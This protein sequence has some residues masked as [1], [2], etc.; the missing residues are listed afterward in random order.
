MGNAKSTAGKRWP[1]GPQ[2]AMVDPIPQHTKLAPHMEANWAI[3]DFLNYM[4]EHG[5]ELIRLPG[6]L[7]QDL[8]PQ[9]V[10][11]RLLAPG[12]V[13][14]SILSFRGVDEQAYR[15]ES[16]H[17]VEK[18]S[19]TLLAHLGFADGQAVL[20]GDG[21]DEAVAFADRVADESMLRIIEVLDNLRVS[22]DAGRRV[23][24]QALVSAGLAQP[25]NNL[26][27]R[28][29]KLRRTVYGNAAGMP[30][31][32]G[33]ASKPVDHDASATSALLNKLRG[34]DE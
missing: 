15:A 31:Q 9:D 22:T 20:V 10:K 23:C 30:A 13:E 18:Y 19:E 26:L 34:S 33:S 6:V 29:V 24:G 25:N 1:N 2:A 17:L 14:S 4:R 28:A 8:T 21:D 5:V 11:G 16:A 7:D 12:E 27:A 32:L 3:R